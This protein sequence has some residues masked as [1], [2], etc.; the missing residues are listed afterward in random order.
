MDKHSYLSNGD[1]A[2][3]EALYQQYKS[4]NDAV[5]F[6]WKKF[7]E[8]YEL[9]QTSFQDGEAI[10]ENVSKEFKVLKLIDSL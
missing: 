3:F 9:A 2:A 1:D 5:D 8:G 4:N 6:G 10:P 7:F